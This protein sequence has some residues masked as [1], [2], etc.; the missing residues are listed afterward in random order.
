MWSRRVELVCG[1]LGGTLGLVALGVALFAPLGM[2]CVTTT[3]SPGVSGCSHVSLV[4]M[5]GLAGLSFAILIFSGP[6]LG[7]LLFSVWHNLTREG[8]LLVLLWA[9]TIL[10]WFATVLGLLSI[11]LFFVPADALALAAS[12]AGTVAARRR[13]PARV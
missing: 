3:V 13:L 4:E 11:G 2:R 1:V 8:S 5:Q 7:V 10:L 9:S 12:I 6:S